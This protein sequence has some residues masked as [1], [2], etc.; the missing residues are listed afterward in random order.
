MTD[1]RR[2]NGKK[3]E[4]PDK[5]HFLEAGRAVNTHGVRGELKIEPWTD[6]PAFLTRFQRITVGNTEYAV[7]KARV[8]GKFVL[9][10]LEGVDSMET[11]ETMK[12]QSIYIR[13]EDAHL[14]SGTVFL[15]DLIGCE[16][17]D[18]RLNRVI[19]KLE[20]LLSLPAGDIYRVV[21]QQGEVLIPARPEFQRG[22]EPEKHR[23]L[24]ETIPGMG[25]DE[26]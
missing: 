12:T 7:E 6:S 15:A 11:A 25:V 9:V 8:H 4:T 21:S 10:K 19:G 26:E 24:V 2:E 13:R 22:A 1:E 16:V 23:L 20:E 17:F 5:E 3:P 14:P 18:L